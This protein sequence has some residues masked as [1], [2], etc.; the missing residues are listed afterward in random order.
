MKFEKAKIVLITDDKQRLYYTGFYSTD[1]HVILTESKTIFVVD[2]RYYYA[3]HNKLWNSGIEVVPGA[4]YS[5]LKEMLGGG[6]VLGVDFKV[7]S[8]ALANTLRSLGAELADVGD[9]IVADMIIKT[10]REIA[11]VKKAADIAEKAYMDT[12][13]VVDEGVTE[14]EVAAF[15]EYN[16]GMRGASGKSFDTIVAFGSNSAVPHHETGKTR[17]RKNMPIL[18]DFGC[19]YEGYCSDMTRTV[20]FGHPT[21]AFRTAYAA[22]LEAHTTAYENIRA[23]MTGA[24]ADGIARK[25]LT[26]RG[27]PTQ[28]THSLGHGIGVNIHE[29]PYVGPRSSDRLADGMIFSIEPGVYING[30]F[31]IRIEDTVVMENGR[32][33]TLMKANKQL[34]A[35]TNGVLR[36]LPGPKNPPAAK[37]KKPQTAAGK[38]KKK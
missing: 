18:M 7:T 1:G 17:L 13:K 35:V 12:L 27:Y 33:K 5:L 10:E 31:G 15:L 28:F 19:V 3:A 22:V 4:D 2:N 26:S 32:P 30:R 16:F 29:A 38:R 37:R 8:M 36:Y 9:E 6:A 11:L 23:G 20:Y 34:M 21:D 14:R 25:L 24:E